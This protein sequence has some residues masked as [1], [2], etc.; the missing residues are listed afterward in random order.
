[1]LASDYSHSRDASM[2]G[3]GDFDGGVDAE[4]YKRMLL[5]RLRWLLIN[6]AAVIASRLQRDGITL[7]TESLA[8]TLMQAVG[9]ARPRSLLVPWHLDDATVERMVRV[10]SDDLVATFAEAVA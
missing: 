4:F 6:E 9:S 2:S 10:V 5:A 7:T 8:I 3:G 1:M